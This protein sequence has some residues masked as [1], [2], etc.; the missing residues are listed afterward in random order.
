MHSFFKRKA[1]TWYFKTKKSSLITTQAAWILQC[2]D[3]GACF[4]P[5][6]TPS[7]HAEQPSVQ[8]HWRS[9]HSR[10]GIHNSRWSSG[11]SPRWTRCWCPPLS[12]RTWGPPWWPRPPP[13]TWAVWAE[14]WCP[15][16]FWGSRRATCASRWGRETHKKGRWFL[17]VFWL[18]FFSF[19]LR[20]KIK[21]KQKT[22]RGA[23]EPLRMTR[24][25][26]ESSLF[27]KWREEE[28]R[29]GSQGWVSGAPA[30]PRL[31]SPLLPS[32]VLY[33]KHPPLSARCTA[34]RETLSGS[35][36]PTPHSR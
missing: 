1:K 24:W 31:S 16:A 25:D 5:S 3:S 4:Q 7:A 34:A 12:A 29:K 13:G 11:S 18:L 27:G 30:A 2:S 14:G 10:A 8:T 20:N 28:G 23:C 32:P 6:S 19:F 15:K 36:W 17:F 9:W 26:R 33:T 21:W 22:K 35:D